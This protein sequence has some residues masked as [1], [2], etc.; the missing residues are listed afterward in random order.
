MLVAAKEHGNRRFCRTCAA[1]PLAGPDLNEWFQSSSR[2]RYLRRL[3]GRFFT[4]YLAAHQ[5]LE[6]ESAEMDEAA[7]ENAQRHRQLSR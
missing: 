2:P 7:H 3:A 5:R 4:A 1:R 6:A